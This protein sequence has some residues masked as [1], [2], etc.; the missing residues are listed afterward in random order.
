ML[1][2]ADICI[3]FCTYLGMIFVIESEASDIVALLSA[4]WRQ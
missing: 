4:D 1:A 3:F 2:V